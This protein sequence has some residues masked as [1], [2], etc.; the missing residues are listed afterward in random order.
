MHGSDLKY[1]LSMCID[2]T[3]FVPLNPIKIISSS[4]MWDSLDF[5]VTLADVNINI[6]GKI[7]NRGRFTF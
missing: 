2:I 3:N 7:T 1:T 6:L 4:Q 5:S